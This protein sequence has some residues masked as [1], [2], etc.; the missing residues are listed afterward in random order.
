MR[1]AERKLSGEDPNDS[2]NKGLSATRTVGATTALGADPNCP[3][4]D[5][6]PRTYQG[7][8]S[9]NTNPKALSDTYAPGSTPRGD[10]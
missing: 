10:R 8:I 9:R 3:S 6:P 5:C 2:M 1:L 4:G 7:P